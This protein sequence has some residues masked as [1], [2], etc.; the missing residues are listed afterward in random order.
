M[1]K[2]CVFVDGE[3]FRHIVL[4]LFEREMAVTSDYLP[5]NANWAEFFDMVVEAA[6][7]QPCRRV[8]TYWYV[9]RHIDI[10]PYRLPNTEREPETFD[11]VVSND[12]AYREELA[13]AT[14]D[15][16]P[17]VRRRIFFEL[18]NAE[19]NIKRKFEGYEIVQDAV[20]RQRAVEFR[21]S[22]SVRYDL[23]REEFHDEKGVDVRLAVDMVTLKDNYDI[24]ILIS[25]DQDYTPAVQAVKDA[26]KT[27]VT[28]HF[29]DAAGRVHA[30]TSR[31]LQVASDATVTLDY[32]LI[33]EYLF[34][35]VAALAG[36]RD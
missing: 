2:A 5:R 21:R 25:G 20:A 34:P 13:A 9:V 11:R 10:F 1:E 26:G 14:L 12:D 3:N 18:R 23:F 16:L 36:V 27:V 33:R 31:R 24:A 8:R 7:Q 6:T 15:E 22:G 35:E 28:V 4:S 30:G 32:E 19:T 17:D 29:Q